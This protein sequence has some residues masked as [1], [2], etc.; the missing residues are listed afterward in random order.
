MGPGQTIAQPGDP[1][2]F[3]FAII[4]DTRHFS[5]SKNDSLRLAAGRIST[6]Q[7]TGPVFVM[8][9]LVDSCK[10]GSACLTKFKRWKSLVHPLEQRIFPVMGNH[11]RTS[12][13]ADKVWKSV[14]SLPKN[15]PSGFAGLDYSFDYGNSHFV[16]LNSEKPRGNIVNSTQRDWLDK[17]LAANAKENTFVFYHEPAFATSVNMEASLDAKPA[18]RDALW[19]IIDKYNVTAVFNGHEHLFSR[20]TIDSSVFAEAHNSIFQITEGNT[21][22]GA[23]YQPK[24][25]QSD[26]SY[27]GKTFTLVNVNGN[28]ITVN[29]YSIDNALID[30]FSFSK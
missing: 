25:G 20:K 4:G 13:G 1:N 24:S 5:T 3:S 14:F 17:N 27:Q 10:G 29:L 21:D 22:V 28:K 8:G 30:S 11:D 18:E 16:V 19:R 12:N 15:G 2:N 7:S 9:D 26:F 6:A 23:G